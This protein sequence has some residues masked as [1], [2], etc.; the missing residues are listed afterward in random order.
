MRAI[1]SLILITLGIAEYMF[2]D[3]NGIGNV[4]RL[5]RIQMTLF[6][7]PCLALILVYTGIYHS[8]K[9]R[10]ILRTEILQKMKFLLDKRVKLVGQIAAGVLIA[11]SAYL[12]YE[13]I[14]SITT[15]ILT[16]E[17]RSRGYLL[18]VLPLLVNFLFL[19]TPVVLY[20]ADDKE[21]PR[22]PIPIRKK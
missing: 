18:I 15:W 12:L 4:E 17:E 13:L 8:G 20:A 9:L 3:L 7:N 6:K 1:A 11:V 19:N 14:P 10:D 16:T 21:E 5:L 22:K 2:W